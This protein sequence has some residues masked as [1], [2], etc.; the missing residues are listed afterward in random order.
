MDCSFTLLFLLLFLLG[1]QLFLFKNLLTCINPVNT[2][3]FR[4]LATGNS[5]KSLSFSFRLGVC[6]VQRIV[7]STCKI[8]WETLHQTFLP[9]PNAELWTETS[10]GFFSR[11]QFPNCVGAIDGKHIRIKKPVRSGS[12]YWNYKGFCSVVLL[13]VGDA[14]GRLLVVDIGSYGS[15]SDGGIFNES[16]FGKLLAAHKLNLPN[17]AKIPHTD[18]TIPH[19]FVADEAFPLMP[20]LMKPFAR[21][22]ISFEKQVFNYRLS[23]ARRQIEC[24]FGIM[25]STWRI[26]LKPIE[27]N[28][29]SAIMTVKAICVLH[30][31][32]LEKEPERLHRITE[33]GESAVMRDRSFLSTS[34]TATQEA[35]GIRDILCNYFVSPT[36]SLPWQNE[37]CMYSF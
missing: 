24:I 12:M 34:R 4:Y 16:Q 22:N 19:L 18:I 1:F 30:N 8:L 14:H 13:A 26:L 29:S 9:C 27:T 10:E 28:V 31:F 6:T 23:R 7:R 11:W 33:S 17:P 20:S 36:G 3:C 25:S 5:F 35:N 21:R 37:A 32:L 15:C 2:F